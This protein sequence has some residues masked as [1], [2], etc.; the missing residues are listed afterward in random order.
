MAR[1]DCGVANTD[2]SIG[3]D[4]DNP[5]PHAEVPFGREVRPIIDVV[6]GRDYAPAHRVISGRSA[7]RRCQRA[8]N[9]RP[10]DTGTYAAHPVK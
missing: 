7:G 10:S 4:S 1:A 5:S 2:P 6:R 8:C 3:R 9:R